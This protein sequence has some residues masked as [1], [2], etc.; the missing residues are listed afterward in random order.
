MT[1]GDFRRLALS[2]PG[3]EESAHMGHP[4][5]RRNGKIFATLQYPDEHWGMVKLSP[6]Q[7]DDLL[8]TRADAFTPSKGAWGR[9][10]STLVRLEA[11]DATVVEH[12]LRL[13][14]DRANIRRKK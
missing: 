3:A 8:R 7:Q 1:P 10:G 6:E 2:L 13:A 14:W 9:Q 11:V 12:A 4:D 5:F